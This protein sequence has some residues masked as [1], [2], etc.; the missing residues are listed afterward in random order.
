MRLSRYLLLVL[1]LLGSTARA[2]VE[3]RF[4]FFDEAGRELTYA[5][6]A[7]RM[8]NGK[9]PYVNSGTF[10]LSSWRAVTLATAVVDGN[11]LVQPITDLATF[12]RQGIMLHWDTENTGYSTFLL[13][14]EGK[15]FT[16][17][18]TYIFN[19]RVA[20]DARRQFAQSIAAK[21]AFVP[22]PAMLTI[23][24]EIDTCFAGLDAATS[25]SEKGSRGQHCTD[26]L[27][28]A[29]RRLMREY[30]LQ[31]ARTEPEATWGVTIQPD[32]GTVLDDETRKV[33]DLADL[34]APVHRWAR[35][36]M[37]GTN[38]PD[39]LPRLRELL[40]YAKSKQVKVMGQL[41]DSTFQAKISLAEHKA[42]VDAALAFPGFEKFDAWE[43]GNEVNGGWLGPDIAA[44]IEY[45]ATQVKAKFPQTRV[46]LTFYW[47]GPEDTMETS[48]FNWI[49][50]HVTPAIRDNIDCVAMSIYI[51]QQPLGFSWDLMMTKLAETFP[52]KRVMIGEMDYQDHSE[53]VY[54]FEGP[55]GLTEE[56]GTQIYLRDRY[57]AAF[58][59]PASVGGGFWWYFDVQM[60]GKTARWQALR[61]VYCEAYPNLCHWKY[62]DISRL[63][64]STWPQGSAGNLRAWKGG[65]HEEPQGFPDYRNGRSPTPRRVR[66]AG[67]AEVARARSAQGHRRAAGK[68][69]PGALEA[70]GRRPGED[71]AAAKRPRKGAAR[72]AARGAAEV[73]VER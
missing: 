48:T 2:E 26:L 38:T 3:I 1:V 67:D 12:P 40:D 54:Y 71:P 50:S 11:Q 36:N 47:Y 32:T 66:L 72:A 7:R 30:G 49:A 44:K 5:E 27:S 56:E 62:P 65:S 53:N 57:P 21:R 41:F 73:S 37:R 20:R 70:R 15:G 17:S 64:L 25:A 51:D 29:M 63:Y 55:P 61:R 59:S 52:G 60:V 33:D 22:S 45:S 46:C 24:R 6:T 39:D 42:K 58:A 16:E 4:R 14:N 28:Q 69:A 35:F 18:A 10:D 19:E 31:H 68:A 43:V 9:A 23:E 8:T 13:D 34:F